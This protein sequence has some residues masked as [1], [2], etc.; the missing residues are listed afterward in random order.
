MGQIR[1]PPWVRFAHP[2]G[3]FRSPSWVNSAHPVGQVRSTR[4]RGRGFSPAIGT[5]IGVAHFAQGMTSD[6]DKA[7][8]RARDRVRAQELRRFAR[9]VLGHGPQ[10]PVWA[11]K[12]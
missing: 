5:A 7:V 1:S 2:V 4:R 10:E 8:Q 12:P 6:V 3:Q 9:H 11:G